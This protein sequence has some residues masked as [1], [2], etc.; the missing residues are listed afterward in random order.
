M[1]TSLDGSEFRTNDN[2]WLPSFLGFILKLKGILGL[3]D[4]PKTW[5]KSKRLF[6]MKDPAVD[7]KYIGLKEDAYGQVE[8][9]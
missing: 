9:I 4:V 8:L 6:V 1:L 5:D 7:V 2:R 3:K